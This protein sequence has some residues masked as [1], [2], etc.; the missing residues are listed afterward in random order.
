MIAGK[1]KPRELQKHGH[2]WPRVQVDPE[3]RHTLD[4]R[5]WGI[6]MFRGKLYVVGGDWINGR[7]VQRRF[8]RVIMSAPSGMQV[9]HINGN[10]LDNRRCNLRICTSAENGRNRKP[11]KGGSSGYKGVCWNKPA[12][13]WQAR[14]MVGGKS[15]SLGY[16]DDEV[17]AARAYDAAACEFHGDFARLNFQAS[18]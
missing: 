8:H 3:D 2:L 1:R 4:E 12:Q 15:I 10:T 9:D 5:A 16:F 18:A 6:C 13:K 7:M 11:R 17:E 14:I